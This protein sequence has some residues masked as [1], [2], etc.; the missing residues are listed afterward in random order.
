MFDGEVTAEVNINVNPPNYR[1]STSRIQPHP[2]A[3]SSIVGLANK[4][5]RQPPLLRRGDGSDRLQIPSFPARTRPS[6]RER[7]P[8]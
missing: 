2:D 3:I 6:L 5:P 7:R 4:I 1:I 8:D